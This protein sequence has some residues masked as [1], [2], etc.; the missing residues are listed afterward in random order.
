MF[1]LSL[2]TKIISIVAFTSV[3][4]AV[5][6]ISGFLYFNKKELERGIIVKE[7]TIH[8]Q[9]A[10]ATRFVA[11]QGGLKDVV[12]KFQSKYTS[13]EQMT[14]TDKKEVMNHV[15][16]VSA[17]I[18]GAENQKTDH[19]KFRVFSDEPRRKENMAT[20]KELEVLKKFDGDSKL[21]EIID[22]DGEVVTLY[23]PVR[24][25]EGNGCLTCH[26]N[27]GNSPWKDGTDILGY[28]MENWKDGKL[29]GVF[30]VS[31][32]IQDVAK[33]SMGS[34]F[35]A[36][37]WYLVGAIT[38]GAFLSL[39]LAMFLMKGS[40]TSL[41]EAAQSILSV[42]GQVGGSA[43]DVAGSSQSLSEAATEQAAS[44]E[45]TAASLEEI[46]SMISKAS[47]S[48]VLTAESSTES[49]RKAEDGHTAVDQM[50][51]SMDEISQSNEAIL[52]QISDSN[53]QMSEIVKVIQD[54]GNRTKI[55]NEIVFQTKLLSFNAS[56][57][58][59]RAG[60]HGKG[61][62]VVAEEV[63][64][65][66]QMSGNAAKEI[67]DMLDASISKVEGIVEDTQKKVEILIQ[68]GKEKIE[69]GVTVAKQSSEVLN[70]IV[71]NVSRVSGL[72]QEISQ[73]TKEQ[74]Q[75]VAEIN[76]AMTQLDSVTQQNASTSQGAATSAQQLSTQAQALKISVDELMKVIRGNPG[77]LKSSTQPVRFKTASR[78]THEDIEEKAG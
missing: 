9:L 48:A 5:I 54:I 18:I 51:T 30:A 72:A 33:A 75:G 61:F 22:N 3:L 17:M 8:R 59:A 21:E 57:E 12:Q 66:A 36:P 44:L 71:Q 10:A 60:E 28:R 49:Q 53:R 34:A 56:V 74:A 46:T 70:E 32:N 67:S 43:T 29:H 13:A 25:S 41:A 39:F 40:I 55:I 77:H 78:E 73:A 42:S 26:G 64:N 19:Y 1:H 7:R 27:P 62:A 24:L 31:E 68:T 35:I 4:G 2:R 16:I 69:A 63:G 20:A 45:Q 52:A 58:A 76:K 14:D 37:S 23:R 47:D 11:T 38:L 65:L 50:L 6:S 15:P